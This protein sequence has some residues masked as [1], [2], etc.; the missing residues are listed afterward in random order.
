MTGEVA[1]TGLQAGEVGLDFI[2]NLKDSPWK[3][4]TRRVMWSVYI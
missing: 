1:G 4:F 2:T 3:V